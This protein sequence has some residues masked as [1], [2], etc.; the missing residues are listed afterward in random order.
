MQSQ[1][2]MDVQNRVKEIC[3][4]VPSECWS[5]CPGQENPVDTP[6]RGL[7]TTELAQAMLKDNINVDQD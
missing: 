1:Q 7:T 3:K 2:G 6:S 5:H 4:L